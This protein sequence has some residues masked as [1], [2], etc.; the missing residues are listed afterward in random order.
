MRDL[1]TTKLAL[2]IS[3]IRFFKNKFIIFLKNCPNLFNIYN[4]SKNSKYAHVKFCLSTELY[5]KYL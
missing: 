2:K 5:G 1:G 4:F 3:S